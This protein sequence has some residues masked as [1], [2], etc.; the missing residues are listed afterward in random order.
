[1]AMILT[2]PASLANLEGQIVVLDI[3]AHTMFAPS[4]RK[5]WFRVTLEAAFAPD[6]VPNKESVDW[7]GD[8]K[9]YVLMVLPEDT[10]KPEEA[11]SD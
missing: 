7:L 11:T 2:E 3:D 9:F 10:I 4:K 8:A 5:N 1:M 6:G